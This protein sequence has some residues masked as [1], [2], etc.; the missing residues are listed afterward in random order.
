M[1]HEGADGELTAPCCCYSAPGRTDETGLCVRRDGPSPVLDGL[2]QARNSLASITL[3]HTSQMYAYWLYWSY[4]RPIHCWEKE[5]AINP[6]RIN[7]Q[8]RLNK[9]K[10]SLKKDS[11]LIRIGLFE[12]IRLFVNAK[13]VLS[14]WDEWSAALKPISYRLLVYKPCLMPLLFPYN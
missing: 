9:T 12:S 11:Q 1:G 14:C 6:T 7:T 13:P 2:L 8:Q 4:Y 3:C 5:N 10:P